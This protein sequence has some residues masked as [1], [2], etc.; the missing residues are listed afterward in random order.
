MKNCNNVESNQVPQ[1]GRRKTKKRIDS[2]QF[3]AHGYAKFGKWTSELS[4]AKL[5]YDGR[6]DEIFFIKVW[7]QFEKTTKS[8]MKPWFP[9]E[10]VERFKDLGRHILKVRRGESSP[11]E[12]TDNKNNSHQLKNHRID[13][14]EKCSELG[15]PCVSRK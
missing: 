9:P 11:R 13:L 8:P 14:C 12:R 2:V 6:K 15:R 5:V 10:T 1:T 3:D 4:W 7:H